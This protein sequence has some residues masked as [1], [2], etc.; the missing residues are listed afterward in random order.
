MTNSREF[1]RMFESV[2]RDFYPMVLQLCIGYMKGDLDTAKDIAQDVFVNAWNSFE[3]FRG[4]SSY[5][6]WIYRIA[7]NTCLLHIRNR[8]NKRSMP[9]DEVPALTTEPQS[10]TADQHAALYGAIGKLDEIDRL[11]IMMVLEELDYSEIEKIMGI[12]SIHLR[13]KIHRIRKKLKQLLNSF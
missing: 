4:D 11:I 5:K 10:A 3:K 2:H 8:K 7:V 6:T 12:N 13:V 1:K 9:L